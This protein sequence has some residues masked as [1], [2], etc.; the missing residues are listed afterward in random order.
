MFAGSELEKLEE[1]KRLLVV[2]AEIQRSRLCLEAAGWSARLQELQNVQRSFTAYRGLLLA[3]AAV[4]G[5]V[6][7]RRGSSLLRWIPA[8][9]GL[10]RSV[11][12]IFR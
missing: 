11:R 8:A 3:G 2:Q 7:A 4:A 1:T 10:W 12:A 5:L 9:L 6:A